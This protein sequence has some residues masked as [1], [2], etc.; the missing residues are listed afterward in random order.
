MRIPDKVRVF[1]LM[2]GINFLGVFATLE[3]AHNAIT[4]VITKEHSY[5]KEG[6]PF[7]HA[8]SINNTKYHA[9]ES[10]LGECL[11]P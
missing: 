6:I 7:L 1:S 8:W 3:A 9:Y 11:K 4:G 10:E 2:Q 5:T